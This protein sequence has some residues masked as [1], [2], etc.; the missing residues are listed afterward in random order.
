MLVDELGREQAAKGLD[1]GAVHDGECRED[2]VGDVAETD[3]AGPE[4]QARPGGDALKVLL[5]LVLPAL[6]GALI[7]EWQFQQQHIGS[8]CEEKVVRVHTLICCSKVRYFSAFAL[9]YQYL[10]SKL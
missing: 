9:L 2:A 1:V 4:G 8:V 5:D 3:A 10:T 6:K 7:A